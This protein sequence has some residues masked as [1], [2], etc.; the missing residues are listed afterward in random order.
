[1]SNIELPQSWHNAGQELVLAACTH[2]DAAREWF[3]AGQRRAYWAVVLQLEPFQDGNQW[4]FLW[5][6]NL[7]SGVSG[8]GDTPEKALVAFEQAMSSGFGC[9]GK[10]KP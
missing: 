1:M 4:C 6:A 10:V 3:Q 5:G 8:F 7:Q 9:H 2:S